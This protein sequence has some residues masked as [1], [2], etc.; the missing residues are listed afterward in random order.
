MATVT[1]AQIQGEG[2]ERCHTVAVWGK[3]YLPE[4]GF[5]C[6][7]AIHCSPPNPASAARN[8]STSRSVHDTIP[9]PLNSL[10]KV[11]SAHSLR[12]MNNRSFF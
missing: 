1:R 7:Q 4:A 9:V 11:A 3:Y 8:P 5:D 10:V 12:C 2:T 6:L